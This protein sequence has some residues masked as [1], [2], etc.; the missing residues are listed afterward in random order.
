MTTSINTH[1][2]DTKLTKIMKTNQNV[3]ENEYKL[4]IKSLTELNDYINKDKILDINLKI[5]AQKTI[6][7]IANDRK[8]NFDEKNHINL[9]ILFPIIW[10]K[11]K[12]LNNISIYKLYIEQISDI[13][14]N[15]QCSQGR[16]TRILQFYNIN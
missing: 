1:D 4:F 14:T 16:T 7:L 13:Y 6:H 11:I 8:N 5:N 9:E 15:G 12:D 3:T 10:T 2:Y